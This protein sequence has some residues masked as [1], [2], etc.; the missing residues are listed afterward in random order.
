MGERFDPAEA[1]RLVLGVAALLEELLD[2]DSEIDRTYALAKR[3]Q[4]RARELEEFHRDQRKL[5]DY[6]VHALDRRDGELVRA[7]VGAFERRVKAEFERREKEFY[8]G[9][10]PPHER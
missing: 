1:D 10:H 7:A 8:D 3:S 6:V 5:W 4:R 9:P 2:E